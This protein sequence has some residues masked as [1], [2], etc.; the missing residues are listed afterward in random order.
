[1]KFDVPPADS[2]LQAEH[3]EQKHAPNPHTAKD[4]QATEPRRSVSTNRRR[5]RAVSPSPAGDARPSE[6]IKAPSD[7]RRDRAVSPGP[8]RQSRGRT[9]SDRPLPSFDDNPEGNSIVSVTVLVSHVCFYLCDGRSLTIVGIQNMLI[10]HI[11][12]DCFRGAVL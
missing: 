1:M 5:E 3:L 7:R 4:L 8:T 9:S 6:P 11:R 2:T 10:W 12:G